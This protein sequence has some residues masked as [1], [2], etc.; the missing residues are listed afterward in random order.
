MFR[1]GTAKLA[2]VVIGAFSIPS[3]AGATEITFV[4]RGTVASFIDR[5][6]A[7]GFGAGAD[8]AGLPVTDIYVVDTTSANA[9]FSTGSFPVGGVFQ[10]WNAN[11]PAGLSSASSTIGGHT[12]SVDT[13]VFNYS[14]RVTDPP[15]PYDLSLIESQGIGHQ[16][17]GTAPGAEFLFRDEAI[18]YSHVIPLSLTAS[19][20][21]NENILTLNGTVPGEIYN[22]VFESYATGGTVG[23]FDITSIS[24][25]GGMIPEPSTWTMLLAGFAT[26]GFAGY[27]RAR[28]RQAAVA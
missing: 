14:E 5:T 4:Y 6:N 21:L 11:L 9:T 24:V 23:Y 2:F 27:R 10:E 1:R 22:G 28:G 3:G 8:L 7:Y 20:Y 12:L 17:G 13:N 26:L 19:Y 25:N 15:G 16:V 18:S